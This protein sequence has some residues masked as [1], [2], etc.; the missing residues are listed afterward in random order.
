VI[1]RRLVLATISAAL[2]SA[3]LAAPVAASNASCTGQFV[4]VVARASV[5]LGQTV[6]VPEVRNLFLGGPN[7]GQEVKL[8]LATADRDA[9]PVTP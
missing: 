1:R 7:L 5:P 2:A 9:C 4:S 6:V 8:L 3:A